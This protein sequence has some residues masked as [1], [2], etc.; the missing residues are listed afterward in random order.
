MR[1][2]LVT[3]PGYT[4][5][6]WLA[7][8]L[9]QAPHVLCNHSAGHDA[10][11]AEAYD[12]QTLAR[13]AAEKHGP[14]DEEPV[15]LFL[16]ALERRGRELGVEAVG[17]VHRYSLTAL[18]KNEARFGIRH[19]A[20]VINLVRH[21]VPWLESGAAQLG[22]L[23]VASPEVR[24]R[25]HRH[26]RRF[27]PQYDALAIPREPWPVDL[28]FCYLCGRLR[29]LVEEAVDDA[30]HVRM[31][32]VTADRGVLAD[33]FQALTGQTA[34]SEWLTR[35]LDR[36]RVHRHRATALDPTQQLEA[37]EPWKL[38]VFEHWA[39]ETNLASVYAELG[40]SVRLP[41]RS[42]S[43]RRASSPAPL[44]SPRTIERVL[45]TGLRKTPA[46]PVRWTRLLEP[47]LRRVQAE[48]KRRL[49]AA[50]LPQL[51]PRRRWAPM[52]RGIEGGVAPAL[53]PREEHSGWRVAALHPVTHDRSPALYCQ[54][55]D[56]LQHV[57]SY[58]GAG[59]RSVQ[60]SF[61]V[62]GGRSPRYVDALRRGVR[63]PIDVLF[64]RPPGDWRSH[65]LVGGARLVAALF[66]ARYALCWHALLLQHDGRPAA[67]CVPLRMW[68]PRAI[69]AVVAGH[70]RVVSLRDSVC[71]PE[72]VLPEQYE[73]VARDALGALASLPLPRALVA[74]LFVLRKAPVIYEHATRAKL[75]V[76][77][78]WRQLNDE[79]ALQARAHE[80][81]TTTTDVIDAWM[82]EVFASN[83][84]AWHRPDPSVAEPFDRLAHAYRRNRDEADALLHEVGSTTGRTLGA[85]HGSGGHCLG[86]RL[87][88]RTADGHERLDAHGLPLRAGA[89]GGGCCAPRNVTVAGELV[90]TTHVYNPRIDPVCRLAV[91]GSRSFPDLLW[92]DPNQA[93]R[94]QRADLRLAELSMAML[95]AIVTGDRTLVPEGL[96]RLEELRH[97]RRRLED[98]VRSSTQDRQELA[99]LEREA[100]ELRKR[101]PDA[102]GGA[103]RSA[104]REAYEQHR[105]GASDQTQLGT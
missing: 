89:P 15:P 57:L 102:G 55:A 34:D 3:S 85:L 63:K 100:A 12:L 58:K 18:R 4:A 44:C 81:G 22:R 47:S 80:A 95:D 69:E 68:R 28:A 74:R 103:C 86:R 52:S 14:R 43:V 27:A 53:A 16:E 36:G 42:P 94:F 5:T 83:G 20:T 19:G 8:A 24:R 62:R 77:H 6:K 64:D 31:E 41:V 88:L 78:L 98:R 21:P 30:R 93:R 56:G 51:D 61:V 45:Q 46:T 96:E 59:L 48:L 97:R 99:A 13:L 79:R 1:R 73:Q 65:E 91:I 105:R 32:D 49:E 37:W 50:G 17:N 82:D 70:R 67:T 66:E 90:D 54:H 39:R 35:V 23:I 101:M 25:V 75:R 76:G 7:W 10:S 33:V 84:R 26:A 2:F 104:F 87:K 29:R 72:L 38:R 40:Y 11:D 60:D 9:D 92:A 71:D